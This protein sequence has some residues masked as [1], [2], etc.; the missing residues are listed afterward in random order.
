MLIKD[1]T[2][3]TRKQRTCRIFNIIARKQK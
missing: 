3:R 1:K 2:K